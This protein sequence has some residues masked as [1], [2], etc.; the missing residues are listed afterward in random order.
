MATS[1]NPAGRQTPDAL[2]RAASL[3]IGEVLE[4]LGVTPAGLTD[5]EAEA[6]LEQH[7]PNEVAREKRQGWLYRLYVA[8]RNPLVIL[9][10]ALAVVAFATEDF[11]AGTVMLLM[12]ALGLALRFIQETRA[13]TAAAR[14]KAMISVTA[15]VIRNG[16]PREIPL[17]L[18]VPG[19]IVK[20]SAGDMIPADVRLINAKDLFVIQATLTGESMPVEKS[21]ARDTRENLSSI[22][23]SNLCF[24][25]TS[26]ESGSA[27]ALIVATGSQTCFGKM[28]RTL[29]GQQPD[30]AFDKGVKKYTWLMI[31]FMMVMVPLVF[32]INGI[33]RHD[34]HEAFLF[35]LAVAVMALA[36]WLPYSPLA[37]AL[38]FVPLPPL[39]WPILLVTLLCYVGLTQLVKTWLIRKSWV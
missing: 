1:N 15:T 17:R 14:L 25:G 8:A 30:T 18:L 26:V 38:G 9:L 32:V 21:E 28:A 24:L 13:D 3:E 20:L 23:R 2:V 16:Q 29:A 36:A 33:T 12:V 10:L 7:G 19:D 22:E 37:P 5:G 11:R 39:Y 31:R 35:S 6:R 4:S 34:W 27:L